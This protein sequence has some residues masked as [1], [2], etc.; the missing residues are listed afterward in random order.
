MDIWDNAKDIPYFSKRFAMKK[1]LEWTDEEI[2]VSERRN[3]NWADTKA[4]LLDGLPESKRSTL[5]SLLENQKASFLAEFDND[6]LEDIINPPK[7]SDFNKVLLPIIRRIV[8]A[9]LA[10]ELVGVQ[11]MT[12]DAGS[13][14]TLRYDYDQRSEL[15]QM[16]D[17]AQTV[18][19]YLDTRPVSRNLKASWAIEPQQHLHSQHGI[20]IEN[21]LLTALSQ[22]VTDELDQ[23]IMGDLILLG[24]KGTSTHE[25]GIFYC[26][27]VPRM[28]TPLDLHYRAFDSARDALGVIN[29]DVIA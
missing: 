17:D 16:I 24:Y 21:E 2:E 4:A 8:P 25:K 15:E 3:H 18:E 29:F 26:P 20:D 5:D 10:Q 12:G 7:L 22:E 19:E 23:E 9:T 14:Y 13:I 11:P 27:Y 6:E 28:L 1:Y